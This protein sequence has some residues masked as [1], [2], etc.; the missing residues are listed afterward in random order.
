MRVFELISL[1]DDVVSFLLDALRRRCKEEWHLAY[2]EIDV[3]AHSPRMQRTLV[4]CGFV[5]VAYVPALAFHDVERIDVVKMAYVASD[6]R[7]EGVHLTSSVT[8]ARDLVLSA[9]AA[10]PPPGIRDAVGQTTLFASLTDEQRDRVAGDCQVLQF[11]L[12][13]LLFAEG[14]DADGVHLV[15]DG[16][17]EIRKGTPDRPVGTVGPP[18]PSARS[19]WSLGG[20]HSAAAVATAVGRALLISRD[21]FLEL[22]C[23]RP[24]RGLPVYRNLAVEMA[25]KLKSSDLA[26]LRTR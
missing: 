2:I 20:K 16:E 5:P 10:G 26:L 15:L 18:R 24:D 4:A 11:H 13:D 6:V 14:D 19:R 12:G 8:V 1:R 9:L 3:S 23:Q 25:L 21:R 22:M 17:V 7:G